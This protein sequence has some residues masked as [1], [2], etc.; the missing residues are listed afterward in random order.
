[1]AKRRGGG[2]LR[3]IS[4]ALIIPNL[5]VYMRIDFHLL[6]SSLEFTEQTAENA[7]G[8]NFPATIHR[9]SPRSVISVCSV[10]KFILPF[11]RFDRPSMMSM[12]LA[13]TSKSIT[14]GGLSA[15]VPGRDPGQAPAEGALVNLLAGLP[16]FSFVC[17][18]DQLDSHQAVLA[19]HVPDDRMGALHL[20]EARHEVASRRRAFQQALPRSPDEVSA[21]AQAIGLPP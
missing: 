18:S 4:P 16:N 3:P 5:I 17:R 1:M 7:R 12:H 15:D 2:E 14:I 11:L 8:E 6:V 19:A 10:R 20:L 9:L 21:A 13:A